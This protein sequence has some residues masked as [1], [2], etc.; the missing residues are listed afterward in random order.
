MG[1]LRLDPFLGGGVMVKSQRI[2]LALGVAALA[3]AAATAFAVPAK[4]HV[5]AAGVIKPGAWCGGSLWKLMTLSDTGNKTVNWNAAPTNIPTLASI[6]APK[7]APTTRSTSFEKQLWQMTLVIERYRLQ[8]NGE[9]ALELFDIP[10]ATYMDAYMPNPQCLSSSTRAR[11]QIVAARTAFTSTCP[12]PTSDWQPLG[13]SVT[14]TGVG[15]WNPV[16]TTLG[17]LGNGAELRPVTGFSL[18]N[19]CGKF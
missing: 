17:A 13:A 19:G 18:I 7:K 16:K 11:G 2:G 12:A 8:S 1:P 9:I 15:F 6:V 3:A 10:S 4:A 5:Q 14:L